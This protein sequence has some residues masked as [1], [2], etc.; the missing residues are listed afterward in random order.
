MLPINSSTADSD[1]AVDSN[2]NGEDSRVWDPGGYVSD[3]EAYGATL[4]RIIHEA[5]PRSVNRSAVVRQAVMNVGLVQ[6][7]MQKVT[8]DTGASSGNYIGRKALDLFPD[9]KTTPCRHSAKLA[10]GKSVVTINEKCIILVSPI[11]DYGEELEAISTEFYIV[12]TLGDEAIIGLPDLLG[13]YFEYF[14][15]ILHRAATGKSKDKVPFAN[16]VVSDLDG[17]CDKMEDE[18]YKKNPSHKKLER[19]VKTARRKLL[20]YETI[21]SHVQADPTMRLITVSDS[22]EGGV[23]TTY[24]ASD[25]HGIVY[26]DDRVEN[27]VASME[28]CKDNS[29]LINPGDIVKPWIEKPEVCPEDED[30]P[31]PLSFNED[32]LHFMEMSVEDSQQ[33]YLN[34]FSSHVN[35]EMKIAVPEVLDLL[36]RQS[37]VECFAPSSWNGLKKV[38]PV[39]L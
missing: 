3:R 37:S 25:T 22:R 15:E 30:T 14:S 19:L 6:L 5:V 34:D 27:I 7:V 4:L 21:K 2:R 11:N 12:E 35:N 32:V 29:L 31:D 8:Y 20:S 10:D 24:L 36:A 23:S 33:E 13:N 39:K 26:S 16:R 28:F 18:L 9:V 17:L 38:E 1:S